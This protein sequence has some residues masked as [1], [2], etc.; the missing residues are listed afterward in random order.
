M[1]KQLQEEKEPTFCIGD[2]Q[3]MSG[4]A[5]FDRTRHDSPSMRSDIVLNL[6]WC[7]WNPLSIQ[8]FSQ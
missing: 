4:S 8:L 7:F 3:L 1:K 2:G 5:R 6:E